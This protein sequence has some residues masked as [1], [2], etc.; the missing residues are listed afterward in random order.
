MYKNSRFTMFPAWFI[1]ISFIFNIFLGRGLE[2]KLGTVKLNLTCLDIILNS[3]LNF[4]SFP[5][6]V[7]GV[8]FII[9]W[10]YI[11]FWLHFSDSLPC[12]LF[13]AARKG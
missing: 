1:R 12:P 4:H 10:P 2:R 7:F 11:Y 13:L 6:L 5:R 8:S 9:I 3:Q